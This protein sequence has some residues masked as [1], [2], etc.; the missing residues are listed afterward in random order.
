MVVGS[1]SIH[2]RMLWSRH[3]RTRTSHSVLRWL[4][5]N[6]AS[7]KEADYDG[8]TSLI[9]AACGG[10]VELVDFFISQGAWI[11]ERNSNGDTALLLA[12]YCGY[13][14]LVDW[15]LENGA[16][17]D[18]RNDT[19]MGALISAANGGVPEVVELLLQR[20]A[21]A[22]PDCGDSLESTDEGGYTPLLL[23]AQRGHLEVVKLLAAY[24]AN[25]QA[26]TSLH[27]NNAIMLANEFPEVQAYLTRVWNMRPLQIAV[28]NNDYKRA[29]ALVQAGVDTLRGYTGLAPLELALARCEAA[30]AAAAA[31]QAR[32]AAV[33]AGAM[34]VVTAVPG[35]PAVASTA[36]A[37]AGAA[38]VASPAPVIVVDPALVSL[39][40]QAP[41]PWAPTRQREM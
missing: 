41:L 3:S 40:R 19:G 33:A 13:R 17:L 26:V 25:V 2:S 32:A 11:K 15:L 35:S 6:G 7:L 39:L 10:N 27:H 31:E 23:A 4:L 8:Y 28:E 37:D 29:Y 9:L 34:V 30:R 16:S 22:G 20:I 1:Q 38:V 12:S 18:E 5:N 24:G 21:E 36:G 14:D